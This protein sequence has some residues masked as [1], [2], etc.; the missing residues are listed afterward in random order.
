[1]NF[2]F[3][4]NWR[5]KSPKVPEGCE[6]PQPT[7]PTTGKWKVRNLAFEKRVT[8]QSRKG[9]A[10]NSRIARRVQAVE[11]DIRTVKER[12]VQKFGQELCRAELLAICTFVSREL[13]EPIDRDTSR[14]KSALLAWCAERLDTFLTVLA[15]VEG[16]YVT[17]PEDKRPKGNQQR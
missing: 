15:G 2:P 11:R 7:P 14:R 10:E 1:M 12:I 3:Y 9:R 17:P 6:P 8:A 16:T 13:N 4:P 5:G